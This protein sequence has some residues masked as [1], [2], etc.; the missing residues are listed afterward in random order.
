MAFR[1]LAES[2]TRFVTSYTLHYQDGFRVPYSLILIDTPGFADSS[3]IA[4]DAGT[5]EA[6]LNITCKKK[7]GA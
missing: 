2:M 5:I 3:G 7:Y 1:S 4:R 6:L